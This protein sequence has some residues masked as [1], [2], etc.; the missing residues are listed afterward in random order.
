MNDYM[1]TD[2]HEWVCVEGGVAIMGISIYAAE[3]LG[4]IVY[5]E[6][7]DI[8]ASVSQGDEIAVVESVKAASEIYAPVSGVVIEINE[9]LGEAPD[10]VN[11]DPRGEGW[12]LKL[13]MNKPADLEKLMDEAAYDS[14]IEDLG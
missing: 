5:V 10:T 8:G 1:Y 4:D 12:L 14:F 3:Q 11:E 13:K 9:A 6:L 7:P 2:Q